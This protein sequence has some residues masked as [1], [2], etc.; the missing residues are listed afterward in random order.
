M[1]CRVTNCPGL[2]NV[3]RLRVRTFNFKPGNSQQNELITVRHLFFVV[4]GEFEKISLSLKGKI[5]P[6]Q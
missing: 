4:I 1:T 5:P 3:G 2:P 6:P